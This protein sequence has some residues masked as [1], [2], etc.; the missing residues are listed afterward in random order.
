A[1]KLERVVLNLVSNALK[2]APDGGHVSVRVLADPGGAVLTVADDGPGVPVHLREAIF[3][4]FRQADDGAARRF[5]GTGLGLAIAREIVEGHGGR[6]GVT[7]APSGGPLFR[8]T[9]PR[10]ASDAPDPRDGAAI[11]D[12]SAA[13]AAQPTI[14]EMARQTIAELRPA[15][16]A[17]VPPSGSGD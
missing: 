11:V 17:A 16:A 4:R 13:R 8:V 12:R 5:G 2:F 14:D 15:G 7:E 6:I 10:N 9:L 3:E 1:G